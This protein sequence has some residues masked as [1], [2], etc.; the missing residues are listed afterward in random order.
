MYQKNLL[1][2]E[3]TRN[4]EKIFVVYWQ[5]YLIA[6]FIGLLVGIER[7]RVHPSQKAMGV[8]T[9]LLISL[10][11]AIAGGVEATW[12]AAA[13]TV[14][15]LSLILIAY[16]SQTISSDPH[17]DRGLT[18]EF[19]AGIVFCLGYA[20]HASPT[21]SALMGPVVA[22]IL[23]S[24]RSLHRF[25]HAIKSSEL[26]AALLLLLGGVA[27]TNLAP[28]AV[29]DH[30]GI[31]NPRKFGYLVLTLAT[32]EFSSYVMVKMV[33][34]KKGSLLVGFLGGLVSSTAVLLSSARRAKESPAAWRTLL[35]STLAA[36]FAAIVE[37]LLIVGV[38]APPL[39]V[40]SAAPVGAGLVACVGA[41]VLVVRKDGQAGGAGLTLK[42]PL[43]WRGVLRLSILLAAILASISLAKLWLGDEATLALSFLTGLFELHGISLANA[44]MYQQGHLGLGSAGLNITLA[45][46]ASLVAKIVIAWIIVGGRF[47]R[48]LT[49]VFC[50]MVLAIGAAAWFSSR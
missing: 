15:A 6:V 9:F 34:Q 30:W 20:A 11:G 12:L 4:P 16:F 13:L 33:G 21:L 22:L 40:V 2:I 27:V 26:E 38:I 37:L 49:A 36:K 18:T 3:S 17:A 29:I 35:G 24:K 14:F 39:L 47:A 23:F 50:F 43:D 45:L 1:W 42:S 32:L 48:W 5:P 31:F 25:T 28:D 19:A 41:L 46:A 7:E 44:T 10:L 8:R